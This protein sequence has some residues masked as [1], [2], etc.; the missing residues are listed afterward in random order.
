MSTHRH[1]RKASVWSESIGPSNWVKRSLRKTCKHRSTTRASNESRT[2]TPNFSSNSLSSKTNYSNRTRRTLSTCC[3]DWTS[4]SF[5]RS[6][7]S[8]KGTSAEAKTKTWIIMALKRMMTMKMTME[9]TTKKTRTKTMMMRT[10]TVV[11]MVTTTTTW[12]ELQL[13]VISVAVPISSATLTCSLM[14]V[15]CTRVKLVASE[16]R[17]RCENNWHVELVPVTEARCL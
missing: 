17:V 9:R 13:R 4:T 8:S 14:P 7:K 6:E 10:M 12:A 16:G 5:T 1:Y 15:V 3:A 2:S 11:K